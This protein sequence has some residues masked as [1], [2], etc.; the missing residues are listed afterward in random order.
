MP[1]KI[2]VVVSVYNM[3]FY[4]DKCMKSLLEQ[5]YQNYEI[6]LVDDGSTDRCPQLCE[7]Y[8]ARFAE[9]VKCI[10]KTNGGLSS[11]RNCGIDA[12]S[13]EYIVFPDPDDWVDPDYLQRLMEIQEQHPGALACC[14]YI[15]EFEGENRSIIKNGATQVYSRDEAKLHLLKDPR[16]NGFAWN[17]LYNVPLIR[18]HNLRFLDDVGPRE[19]LDFAFR[20]MAHVDQAVDAADFATYHYLQRAGSATRSGYS[21][22]QFDGLRVYEKMIAGS[23]ADAELVRYAK[24]AICCNSINLMVMYLNSKVQDEQAWQALVCHVKNTWKE[25][26]EDDST[27]IK[28]KIMTIIAMVCPKLLKIIH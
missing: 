2:T 14:G 27:N 21:R 1:K 23:Q 28:R 15:I 13:G 10:H 4:L 5:T 16:I 3:E 24:S 8:A 25:Y 26:I 19:D 22:K 12:A 6:I 20:Y 9:R 11:A 18:A 17:K 7:D